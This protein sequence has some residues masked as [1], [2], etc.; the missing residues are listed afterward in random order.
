MTGIGGGVGSGG[1]AGVGGIGGSGPGVGAVQLNVIEFE[2][3]VII[4]SAGVVTE[5]V[6]AG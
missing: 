6:P 2:V 3:W 1:G 5:Y 4:V